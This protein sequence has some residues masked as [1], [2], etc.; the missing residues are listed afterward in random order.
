M[1][2]P[3]TFSSGWRFA[4]IR[5]NRPPPHPM[6]T[7]SGFATSAKT[8]RHSGAGACVWS[9]AFRGLTCCRT[10]TPCTFCDASASESSA[11][12]ESSIMSFAPWYRLLAATGCASEGSAA[13]GASSSAPAVASLMHRVAG[14]ARER[15]CV[16]RRPSRGQMA[17]P[18]STEAIRKTRQPASTS[19]A[20]AQMDSRDPL[21]FGRVVPLRRRV[22]YT[23]SFIRDTSRDVHS[24]VRAV[25]PC[26]SPSPPT[27]SRPVLLSGRLRASRSGARRGAPRRAARPTTYAPAC[28]ISATD[29]LAPIAFP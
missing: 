13:A 16:A 25:E 19:V 22:F 12:T 23:I 26:R 27:P 3:S 4:N 14:R 5:S 11:N 29:A 28:L 2:T 6:S 21:S 9:D 10:R 24:S 15:R 17:Q 7:T 8:S 1:S 18:R 20:P